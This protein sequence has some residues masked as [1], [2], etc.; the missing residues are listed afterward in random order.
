[1]RDIGPVITTSIKNNFRSRTLFAIFIGLG[2]MIALAISICYCLL[3]IAPAIAKGG[4]NL[5]S[6]LES[7]LG[8]IMYVGCVAGVGISVNVF[9]IPSMTREKSRGNIESLLAT[10]LKAK[11]IWLGKSLAVFLPGLVLGEV[12]T[13]I[14]LVAINYIYIIPKTDIGFLITPEI[15]VST[16]VMVPIIFF[17]HSLL[18][19]LI[20]LSSSPSSANLVTQIVLP[21]L[22]AMAI[23]LDLHTGLVIASWDYTFISLGIAAAMGIAVTIL[24]PHLT[25][26]RVVLS[27]RG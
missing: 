8:M 26:E 18:V 1:M 23:N 20:G 7:Q 14:V 22:I 13:A 9:A 11:D 16:F 3:L 24:Y 27:R 10:P 12:I 5:K 17:C 6:F 21:L 19:H 2:V 15:A 25:R 4:P